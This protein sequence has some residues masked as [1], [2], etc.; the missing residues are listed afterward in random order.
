MLQISLCHRAWLGRWPRCDA[1]M[2]LGW[3]SGGANV[4]L[5]TFIP[6][7]VM[8]IFDFPNVILHLQTSC[9]SIEFIPNPFLYPLAGGPHPIYE[10]FVR[11]YSMAFIP[12]PSYFFTSRKLIQIVFSWAR[13]NIS[14]A[15]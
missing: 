6:F 4:A 15:P 10:L 9:L 14:R 12:H 2:L 1:V 13:I 5:P 7:T 11:P 8:R 3:K